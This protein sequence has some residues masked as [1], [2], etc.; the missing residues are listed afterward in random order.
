MMFACPGRIAAVAVINAML[1]WATARSTEIEPIGEGPY[2]VAMT[3]LEVS[4]KGEVPMFDYLNG[5]MTASSTVYLTDILTHPEAV[6]TLP[7]AV[8]AGAKVYGA[9]AGRT[10][11]TVLLVAYPTTHDNARPDY[12]FPYKDTGDKLVPHMQRPG[13]RPLFAAPGKFPLIV[14]SG[15]YNTHALWHFE[16][17]KLLASHGY[18]VVDVQHGDGR[19]PSFEGN[20]ALRSIEVKAAVDWALHSPDFSEAIDAERIGVLGQSAGGHTVAAILGGTDPTGRVPTVADARVKMGYGL[21]PFLG[22]SAGI[23]P[24][25]MDLWYFGEDHAGLRAIR[26]PV[27]L[28]YGGSDTN[29]PPEGVEDAAKAL[30]GPAMTVELDGEKHASADLGRTDWKTWEVLAFDAWLRGDP[31]AIETLATAAAVKGG[32]NDHVTVRRGARE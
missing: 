24:M 4:P 13:E 18:I 2:A 12:P 10:I 3:N 1:L 7:I 23:W 17:L 6:P 20:L 16:H 5:K 30:S 8:P 11:P 29:V 28:F 9:L 22:G 14:L 26:K 31:A 27:F 15:G 21:K 32:M 25:K 19:G